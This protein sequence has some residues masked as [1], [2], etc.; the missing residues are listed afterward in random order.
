MHQLKLYIMGVCTGML[1]PAL[2]IMYS[3]LPNIEIEFITRDQDNERI[4]DCG[5]L[6]SGNEKKRSVRRRGFA[7]P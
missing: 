5:V 6:P 4:R 1:I 3:N 2:I 7:N